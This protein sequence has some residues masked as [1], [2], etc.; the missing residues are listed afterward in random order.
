MPGNSGSSWSVLVCPGLSRS[1]QGCPGLSWSAL[2]CPD[3]SW[4][5]LACPGLL[6]VWIL[7]LHVRILKVVLIPFPPISGNILQN[8]TYLKTQLNPRWRHNSDEGRYRAKIREAKNINDKL[9]SL[10]IN[11][12]RSVCWVWRRFLKVVEVLRPILSRGPI[13]FTPPE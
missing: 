4:S 12:Q 6:N 2:V 10:E 1:V 7:A 3:L 13:H 9:F 11:Q 5:V 8:W